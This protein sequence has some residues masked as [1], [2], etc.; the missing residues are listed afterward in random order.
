MAIK[1]SLKSKPFVMLYAEDDE[2]HAELVMLSLKEYQNSHEVYCVSDGEQALDYLFHRGKYSNFDKSPVP[3]LI[4]LDLRMPKK[5][6]M[7]VLKIV[8]STKE[9]KSIPVVILTSSRAQ[10]DVEEAYTYQAN[11][12]LV[13]PMDFPRLTEVMRC[14]W[15]Y[16]FGCNESPWSKNLPFNGDQV[17]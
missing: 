10:K 6:G 5:D 16:W 8:K 15:L 13:K 9:L 1:K 12:Y 17:G 2:S 4:L 3:D 7:E 14:F 11:S